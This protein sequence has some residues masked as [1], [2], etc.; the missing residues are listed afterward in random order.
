MG[1][2]GGS[3]AKANEINEEMNKLAREQFEYYKE[4]KVKQQAKVDEQR[5]SFEAFEFTNPFA[6]AR[7]EF[8]DLETQFENLG[9]SAFEGMENR[10]EDMTVDMRAADFQRQQMQQQ[11]ANILQNLRGAAGT[12][13][14]AGLAQVMANQGA[15]QTQ[16]IAAGIS[17]QERQNQM[18]AAQ[19]G[20]RIDQLQRQAT[21]TGG[22]M[23]RQMGVGRENLIAQGQGAADRLIMQGEAAV[24]GAEF[25]RESTLLAAEYGLLSGASAALQGA[26]SNVMS[27][28]ASQSQ[29]YQSQAQARMQNQGNLLQTGVMAYKIYMMCIPKGT[30]IDAIGGGIKIEDIRPGDMIMGYDGYPVKVLHKHEYLE[31]PSVK[32]WYEIEFSDGA[33]VNTCDMH[34]INGV[35]AKDITE[36]VIS[37]KVY[38]GVELSYDI[39]TEDSGYRINGVPVNSMIPDM[40]EAVEKIKKEIIWQ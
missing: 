23:A 1:S 16:Q 40:G 26:E 14:V 29:M 8:A 39:L 4:E 3:S 30:K 27:S 15:L 36:N 34:K 20:A 25:G 37:K 9:E 2:G 19:E 22:E 11:Q 31:D 13:G 33:K 35:R 12:S 24:Q 28:M 21:L 32:R 38:S 17:Q 5:K 7:N 10:F 6:R 18:M